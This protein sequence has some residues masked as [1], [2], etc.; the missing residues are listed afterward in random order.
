[1]DFRKKKFQENYEHINKITYE[2]NIQ[3]IYSISV[4]SY[5]EQY[6]NSI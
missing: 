6:P 4:L 2:E 5:I 3:F 1:M